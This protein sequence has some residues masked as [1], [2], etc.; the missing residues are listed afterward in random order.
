MFCFTIAFSSF[1]S[2]SPSSSCSSCFCSSPSLS[3]FPPPPSSSPLPLPVPLCLSL[4][5]LFL[6][7]VSYLLFLLDIQATVGCLV[8]IITLDLHIPLSVCPSKNGQLLEKE[9]Y[10]RSELALVGVGIDAP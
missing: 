1:S 2:S 5:L 8:P 10:V 4:L 3:P 7:L 6:L 9:S